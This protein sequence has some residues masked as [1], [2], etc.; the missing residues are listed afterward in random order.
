MQYIKTF[1]ASACLIVFLFV[2]LN[3]QTQRQNSKQ[4]CKEKKEINAK[5]V[6]AKDKIAGV[7]EK[8]ISITPDSSKA[9]RQGNWFIEKNNIEN[10]KVEEE[11][12]PPE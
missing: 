5:Q 4:T 8:E 3:A 11:I 7:R 10:K 6:F 1:F 9:T 12:I 2:H